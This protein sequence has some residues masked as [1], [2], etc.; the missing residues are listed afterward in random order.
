MK[1]SVLMLVYNQERYIAQAVESV[2]AQQTDF[3]FEIVVGEDCSTD[4]TRAVLEGLAQEHPGRIRLLF[5]P[6]NLGMLRNAADTLEACRGDYVAVLEGDDYWTDPEKLQKQVEFLEAH[7][8]CSCCCHAVEYVYDDGRPPERFPRG[9]ARFSG[10]DE[11][12]RRN[13]VQTCSLVFRRRL[14][15]CYP[16]WFGELALGDQA[17]CVLLLT[18]GKIGFL[19]KVMA[20]Y[21]VHSQSVWTPKP[22]VEKLRGVAELYATLQR[23]LGPEYRERLGAVAA[24]Y[25]CELSDAYLAS[26]A[27]EEAWAAWEKVSGL[28]LEP[29]DG[30][31]A[32]AGLL[33]KRLELLGEQLTGVSPQSYYRQAWELDFLKG[34]VAVR[35]REFVLGTCGVRRWVRWVRG[36]KNQAGE[37]SCP[38]LDGSEPVR[39]NEEE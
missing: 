39:G 10:L 18:Q 30:S 31:S 6:A 25:Y 26:G 3:E 2:L 19:D 14:L 21:R 15:P 34:T 27:T 1:L 28:L 12:L 4:S 5:R 20:H 22:R 9:V 38:A 11:F 37:R 32:S 29:S 13:F 17:L 7:P 36:E 33:L 24:R 16:E 8:E 35:L 23:H